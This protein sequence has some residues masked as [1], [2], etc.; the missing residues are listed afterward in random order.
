ML[1][2]QQSKAP[3]GQMEIILY[4]RCEAKPKTKYGE[5]STGLPYKAVVSHLL[6]LNIC[7]STTTSMFQGSLPQNI[8]CWGRGWGGAAE[9]SYYF[10]ALLVA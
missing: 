6:S 8:S 9:A 1:I 4:G 3:F 10:Y 2:K 5:S 7:P